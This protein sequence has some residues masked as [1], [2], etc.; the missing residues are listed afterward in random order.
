MC[1]HSAPIS[2]QC[3]SQRA[4]GVE[5]SSLLVQPCSERPRESRS[6]S[7]GLPSVRRA[8]ILVVEDERHIARLLEFV[9]LKAGYELCI[10]HS[11]EAAILEVEKRHPDALVLDLVLPGM[12]GLEFLRVIRAAPYLCLSA[13]VVL[14]G[15][16][17]EGTS[18][19]L[20]EAGATAHCSKPIAPSSLLR[21]LQ[22]LGI[23]H[24]I[25]AEAI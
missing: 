4:V 25:T 1:R 10:C 21:K 15:Q 8:R 9:L 11:A 24:S 14:S 22:E 3:M 2:A 18:S 6:L 20:Q 17:L 5:G 23:H 19:I 16:W 7:T 12:T 13:V